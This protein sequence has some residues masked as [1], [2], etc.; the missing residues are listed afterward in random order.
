[1]PRVAFLSVNLN[2]SRPL[3]QAE[4]TPPPPT[5]QACERRLSRTLAQTL[6]VYSVTPGW[7]KGQG[8]KS[9]CTPAGA[10]LASASCRP[11]LA[12]AP[13]EAPRS[14]LAS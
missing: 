6:A 4:T 3:P 2:P 8:G 10:T 7:D 12:K 9:G 11:R 14:V 13:P 5:F 1:M